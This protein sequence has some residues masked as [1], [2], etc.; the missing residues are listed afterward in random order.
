MLDSCSLLVIGVLELEDLLFELLGLHLHLLV[1]LKKGLVLLVELDVLLGLNFEVFLELDSK[2]F[3]LLQGLVFL[4]KL[5]LMDTDC[6]LDLDWD[7]HLKI[8]D[9]L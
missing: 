9:L 6:L 7:R 1:F 4:G 8:I 2:C 5:L 3:V